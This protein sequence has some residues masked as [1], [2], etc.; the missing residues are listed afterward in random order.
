[1]HATMHAIPDAGCVPGA[2][3]GG[4]GALIDPNYKTPYAL[5][6]SVGFE[7]AFNPSWTVGASWVHE[8]GVHGYRN[9]QYFQGATLFTPLFAAGDS[10]D[11]GNSFRRFQVAHADNQ[12][13]YDALLNCMCRTCREDLI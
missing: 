13:S 8:Q 4:T 3:A 10:A 6:A 1:M 2:A 9:Y 7:H 5:H 11:K 12:S